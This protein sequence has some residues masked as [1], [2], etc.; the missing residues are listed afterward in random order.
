MLG[1]VILF[2]NT[3]T[4]RQALGTVIVFTAL[5]LDAIES[6]K[7]RVITKER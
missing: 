2:G 6:K 4:N 1:S 3:L 5:L 7:K